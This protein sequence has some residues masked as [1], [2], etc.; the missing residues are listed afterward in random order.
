MA[1]LNRLTARLR[2]ALVATRPAS[3]PTPKPRATGVGVTPDGFDAPSPR[4]KVTASGGN[5]TAST[6]TQN[7]SGTGTTSVTTGGGSVTVKQAQSDADGAGTSGAVT[8]NG[9]GQVSGTVTE[10]GSD[11]MGG[12]LSVGTT[13]GGGELEVGATGR[14]G[15]GVSVKV[16]YAEVDDTTVHS[17]D[18][19]TTATTTSEVRVTVDGKVRAPVGSFGVGQTH[20]ER[21]T[22]QVRLPD[23]DYARVQAGLQPVP[24]PYDP[25]GTLPVG[26]A[27]LMRAGDYEQTRMSGAYRDLVHTNGSVTHGSETSVLV[28]RVDENHVRVTRGPTEVLENTFSVGFGV[29]PVSVG[30]GIS[31]SRTSSY[32]ET[33]EFDVSTPEGKA[34][35][36]QFL[37]DGTWPE[38]GAPGTRNHAQVE[39][40]QGVDALSVHG[41]LGPL[42]GQTELAANDATVTV[43]RHPDGSSTV[44]T[45]SSYGGNHLQVSQ[46]FG[47]DGEEDTTKFK[48]TLTLPNLSSG[49]RASTVYALTGDKEAAAAAAKDGTLVLTFDHDQVTELTEKA[50]ATDP[51]GRPFLVDTLAT[52]QSPYW[53]VVALMGGTVLN[54]EGGFATTQPT[55]DTLGSGLLFIARGGD[56]STDPVPL[57][58]GLSHP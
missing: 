11:G 44:S 19:F 37:L 25:L 10:T 54:E 21:V 26:G 20:T 9:S 6:S 32:Q 41:S 48:A 43:V 52:A 3:P 18:G 49:E 35:Y 15:W 4:R 55:N 45:E 7:G 33:V 1:P 42:A 38:A 56:R 47:P 28:E 39:V 51:A 31:R 2:S 24:S 57:D 27:V 17:G 53:A 36:E 12:S 5:T 13:D 58:V 16:G 46:H 29:G 8:V 30:A 34:A 14:G 22:F 50:K 40:Y 23:A